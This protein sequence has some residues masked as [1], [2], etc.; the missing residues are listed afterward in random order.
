MHDKLPGVQQCDHIT[1]LYVFLF[2]FFAKP[3]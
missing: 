3:L 2:D 1:V